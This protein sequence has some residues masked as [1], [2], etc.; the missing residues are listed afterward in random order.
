M[1]IDRPTLHT[2][3][4][5]LV[6]FHNATDPSYP[7]LVPSLLS[8]SS[9]MY[10][11]DAHSLLTIENI[12]QTAKNFSKYNYTA[13]NGA[14]TYSVGD[15]VSSGGS[16]WEYINATP[17]SGNTPAENSY[18]TEIDS[19]SDYLIKAYYNGIDRMLDTYMNSKKNREVAKSIFENILLYNGGGDLSDKELNTN[20]FVGI[21]IR[22]KKK[23]KHLIGIIN[24]IGHQFDA[25]F[26]GLTLRLYHESQSDALATWSI[27]HTTANSFQWTSL[28]TN[29]TL[30]YV[31]TYDAGGD[32]YLGYYQSDLEALSA[33]A[34]NKNVSWDSQPLS[35]DDVWRNFYKEYSKY[36]DIIGFNV[37]E[38]YMTDDKMFNP[39]YADLT[40][41]RTYGLNLN[42]TIDTDLTPFFIQ[43]KSIV[44]NPLKY[45]VAM[46]LMEGLAY[47]TRGANSL[48]N[49]IKAMAEKQLFHHKEAYGT[50]AD[51]VR[52]AN[53]GLSFDFSG[54]DNSV[55]GS[56][57]K[58]VLSIKS[59]A[60]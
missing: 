48:S 41:T 16:S 29:N 46:V 42:L 25:A 26:E 58:R 5:G 14:T 23:E 52:E 55:M 19:L 2:S 56:D 8:S 10:V 44:S 53:N 37:L 15:K 31:D 47:N 7:S 51:R 21:R 50:L 57:S 3:L 59:G 22:I 24:K 33:Q 20:R 36:F 1:F 27:D 13:Y 54:M 9:G 35:D 28:T 18:W 32:F 30:K 40:P 34:I 39:I 43:E 17:S 11:N 4:F 38:S 6:G 45:N 12:D 49:Q 60:V